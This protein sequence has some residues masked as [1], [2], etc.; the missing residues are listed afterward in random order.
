MKAAMHDVYGDASVVTIRDAAV[1]EPA[2]L[3]M[4]ALGTLLP[5]AALARRRAGV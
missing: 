2:A 3:V 4:L 1:P 5:A